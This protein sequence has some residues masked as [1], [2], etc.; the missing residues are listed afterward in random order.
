MF[1]L[2]RVSENK[3]LV[4]MVSFRHY[5]RC[6]APRTTVINRINGKCTYLSPMGKEI[7]SA[8]AIA[9]MQSFCSLK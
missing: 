4:E 2:Y 6:V 7:D 8:C 9:S 1:A 5:V 3:A